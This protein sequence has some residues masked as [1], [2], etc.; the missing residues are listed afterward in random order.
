MKDMTNPADQAGKAQE[1]AAQDAAQP[2][3]QP[4]APQGQPATDTADNAGEQETLYAASDDAKDKKTKKNKGP[5][6]KIWFARHKVLTVILLIVLVIVGLNIYKAVFGAKKASAS[7][8]QFIRTTTLQKTSLENS[9]TVNGSVAS[10]SVASVTVADTAKTYKVSEVDVEVGDHVNVGDVIA[11]LDTS[12]LATSIKSAQTSYSDALQSAQLAYTRA[13]DAYDTSIVQ[14]DNN[15]IDLQAKIDEADKALSDAQDAQ[16][17]ASDAYDSVKST[18]DGYNNTVNG[19]RD[20]YN[21]CTTQ[22]TAAKTA[23]DAAVDAL[24]GAA[25][26][27]NSAGTM[28]NTAYMNYMAVKDD[29]TKEPDAKTALGSAA[30]ALQ[31]AWGTFGSSI[32]DNVQI[33]ANNARPIAQPSATTITDANSQ[34]LVIGKTLSAPSS[35]ALVDQYNAAAHALADAESAATVASGGKTY[36]QIITEYTAAQTAQTTAQTAVTQADT[37]KKSSDQAVTAAEQGVKA[38]HDAYDSEKNYSTLKSLKQSVEDAAI[39]LTQAKRT[40]DTLTT[41]QDTQADCTLTATMSGTVTALN[42]TVGSACTGTVATIQDTNGL[43]IEVTI[44]AND[45]AKVSTGMTCY[46][47]SDSTGDR[48]IGGTLTQIDPVANDKGTFGAKVTVTGDATDLKIGMQAKVEIL[49]NQTNDVF[50]VP[51]DAIAT[52]ED[53]SS[54]VY[55]KTGGEGVDMTFEQVTVTPGTSN[56]YYTEIS[57]SDLAVGDVIRAS[58]DL[59]QG[60]ETADTRDSYEMAY[61]GEMGGGAVTVTEGSAPAEPADGGGGAPADGGDAGGSNADG[62]D[63]G[64]GNADGGS[65]GGG[66]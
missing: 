27:V 66:M 5:K 62:G 19:L 18:A 7:A 38:A 15:L 52:A 58:A 54:Y 3:P 48:Q 65:Q 36:D 23:Y 41:L 2:T 37:A 24:A 57:G 11:R 31:A 64:G 33:S 45:V 51:S 9:V 6:K 22:V 25:D 26:A 43:T 32:I 53:G 47:T 61:G 44:P 49:Q 12:D 28:Y 59:T 50:A 40:P 14:H 55:R 17:S 34:L 30:D 10:G 8:Y 16:K 39:K 1:A 20:A 21:A 29:T 42:A 46:I 4:A 60:I 13:K 35:G 63:A 56:D